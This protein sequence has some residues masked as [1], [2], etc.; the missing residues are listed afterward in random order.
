M[1]VVT[2]SLTR[3]VNQSVYITVVFQTIQT[4]LYYLHE[5]LWIWLMQYFELR[6][7]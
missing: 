7:K 6:P 3:D 2:F 5:R 4:I 1:L